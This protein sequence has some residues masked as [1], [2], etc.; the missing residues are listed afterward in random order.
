MKRQ[1]SS[2]GNDAAVVSLQ[3]SLY[4]VLAVFCFVPNHIHT[5]RVS[6]FSKLKQIFELLLV[7]VSNS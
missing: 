4:Q 3:C 5:L 1:A 6:D 7:L 2:D